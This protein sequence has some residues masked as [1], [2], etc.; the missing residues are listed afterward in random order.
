MW[1]WLGL[2]LLV[3][4]AAPREP[5]HGPSAAVTV[6][7]PA[8]HYKQHPDVAPDELGESVAQDAG[9]QAPCQVVEPPPLSQ[10][11]PRIRSGPPVTN[12]ISPQV[13]MRP[14]RERAACLRRCYQA[15]L[16][17][18]P[19]LEGRLVIR[20]VVDADGWVRRAQLQ[21]SQLASDDVGE[22]VRQVFLGLHYEPLHDAITVVYPVVFAPD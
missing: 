11:P 17:R 2:V 1:R 16:A 9:S 14:I 10:P 12:Y 4:C 8:P 13:V 18:D 5:D 19:S 22:C 15:G 20:F 21:E 3:S 7:E 6:P